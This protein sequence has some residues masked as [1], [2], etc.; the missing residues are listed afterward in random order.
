MLPVGVSVYWGDCVIRLSPRSRLSGIRSFKSSYIYLGPLI[1]AFVSCTVCSVLNMG[2]NLLNT[3][4]AMGRKPLLFE[5]L[6][7]SAFIAVALQLWRCIMQLA[8]RGRNSASTLYVVVTSLRTRDALSCGAYSVSRIL[9]SQR[10]PI[11]K[12]FYII[13]L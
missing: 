11:D 8:F 3:L 6:W 2:H 12:N 4:E 13:I 5:G 10:R 1:L 7:Q 9:S